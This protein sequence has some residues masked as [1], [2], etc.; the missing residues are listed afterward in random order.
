MEIDKEEVS[1]HAVVAAVWIVKQSGA[2]STRNVC[3]CICNCRISTE[4]N[5]D[6][7][8][9]PFNGVK[10]ISANSCKISSRG[11]YFSS[12][13]VPRNFRGLCLLFSVY[14]SLLSRKVVIVSTLI[15][16]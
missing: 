13:P 1:I 10:H 3:S 11:A 12:N 15:V 9:F 4:H 16:C 7:Q 5:C 6:M 2:L 14:V 8:I